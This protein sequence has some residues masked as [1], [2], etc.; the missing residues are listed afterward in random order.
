[1]KTRQLFKSVAIKS[2]I[3]AAALGG[4]LMTSNAAQAIEQPTYTVVQSN[5]VYEIRKYEPYI[6]AEVVVPGPASEAGSQAFSLLGGYIFGKNKGERKL[7]MTAPV[8]QTPVSPSTPA[9]STKIEM[10]A[11]VVQTPVG[12]GANGTNG[13]T[14][15]LVQFMMP[16]AYTLA[17]LPEP[18]DPKVKLRQVEGK[19]VA[20]HRYS[21][22]WSQ[23]NYD[24]HL[25][26]L[27][28]ALAKAG[29]K[30]QGEPLYSRYNAPFT[31]WFLRKNEIWF[32]I[33][34]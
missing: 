8:V 2:A 1:M 29:V 26:T 5:D 10:T 25:N 18:L 22:S 28:E 9:A 7:E 33:Q 31:P 32:N 20:A 6:V 23:S 15:F 30:T 16:S 21:G 34:P 24:E 17:T 19:T 11:P 27:K 4:I 14:G 3:T 12:N 13:A